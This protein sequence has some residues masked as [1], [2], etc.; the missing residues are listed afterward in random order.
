M[1]RRRALGAHSG[2]P[3]RLTTPRFADFVRPRERLDDP[4]GA[5]L[6]RL[7]DACDE[8]DAAHQNPADPGPIETVE[9]RPVVVLDPDEPRFDLFGARMTLAEAA[10]MARRIEILSD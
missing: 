2:P 1:R 9:H 6:D 3:Q 8:W 4:L 5:A 7:A 10:W